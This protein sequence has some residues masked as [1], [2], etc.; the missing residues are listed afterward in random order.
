VHTN[1]RAKRLDRMRFRRGMACSSAEDQNSGTMTTYYHLDNCNEQDSKLES[2]FYSFPSFPKTIEYPR[3]DTT[4]VVRMLHQ[5]KKRETPFEFT[6]GRGEVVTGWDQGISGMC[7]GEIRKLVL[8]SD[9]A[10]GEA[11]ALPDILPGATLVF[12]IELIDIL[13]SAID[14][15]NDDYDY[16]ND[17]DERFE[18]SYSK[19]SKEINR[20]RGEEEE[21]RHG[22]NRDEL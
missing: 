12:E 1:R 18:S 8:P 10:Y 9:I 4:V 17:D 5:P 20:G 15:D 22:K 21:R 13:F 3:F 6:L 19:D 2:F 11:G 7:V 14:N 16:D